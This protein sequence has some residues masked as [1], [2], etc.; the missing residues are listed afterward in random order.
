M[1]WCWWILS[2]TITVTSWA[3]PAKSKS[4]WSVFSFWVLRLATQKLS[5]KWLI[6]FSTFTR[7]FN[8][9]IKKWKELIFVVVEFILAIFKNFCQS[10]LLMRY[11]IGI[12]PF[13]GL[14]Y[15]FSQLYFTINLEEIFY[16]NKKNAVFMRLLAFR[17]RLGKINHKRRRY[18]WTIS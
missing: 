7:I 12:S 17:K 2:A 18:L 1:Y 6:D 9:F 10:E 14:V 11:H 13:G 16:F 4:A 15:S 3:M 5:L 8:G